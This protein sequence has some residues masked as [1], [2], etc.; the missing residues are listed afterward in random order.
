MGKRVYLDACVVRLT[1]SEI[2]PVVGHGNACDFIGVTVQKSLLVGLQILH[3][4]EGAERVH[5]VDAIWCVRQRLGHFAWCT[6]K[7]R[8]K[9]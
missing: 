9:E 8:R 5:N 6:Q 1:R 7:K 4:N 3:H 2:S